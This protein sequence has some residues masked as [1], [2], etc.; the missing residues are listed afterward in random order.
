MSTNKS[1]RKARHIAYERKQE[2]KGKNVVNWIFGA[3]VAMAL[4]FLIYAMYLAS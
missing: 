3:L 4:A 2:E 1:L